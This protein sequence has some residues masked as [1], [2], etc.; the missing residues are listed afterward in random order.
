MN[1]ARFA[2]GGTNRISFFLG[3]LDG[4][5]LAKIDISAAALES[6]P[7]ER[8]GRL[9]LPGEEGAACRAEASNGRRTDTLEGRQ[10]PSQP[11]PEEGWVWGW[12]TTVFTPVAAGDTADTEGQE[13]E[14]RD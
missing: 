13:T 5:A 8:G 2:L 4:R 9:I 7:T 12:T 14:D 6:D 11:V 10:R 1:G 3:V